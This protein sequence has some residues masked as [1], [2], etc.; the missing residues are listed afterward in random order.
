MSHPT[1]P[2][3]EAEARPTPPSRMMSAHNNVNMFSVD[4]FRGWPPGVSNGLVLPCSRCGQQS[5]F[6]YHVDGDFWRKVV[7]QDERLGVVCLPCLDL[8][9]EEL[10]MEV[11]QHLRQVQF[12][13]RSSTVFL[14]PSIT[15]RRVSAQT[16]KPRPAP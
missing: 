5:K 3:G 9:A 10:G 1:S 4:D 6:D 7:P 8:L 2:D 15:I 14:A 11:G 16:A 12:T 13:G